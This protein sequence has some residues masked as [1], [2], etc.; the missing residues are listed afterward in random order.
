MMEKLA[1]AGEGGGPGV[2]AYTPF[3]ISTIMYK[4][5]VYTPAERGRY[6]PSIS[7]LPLYVLCGS[8]AQIRTPSIQFGRGPSPSRTRGSPPAHSRYAA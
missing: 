5:V 1:Q 4:Y 2:L 6:T 8:I 7:I 3:I